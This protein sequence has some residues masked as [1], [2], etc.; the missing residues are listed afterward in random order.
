MATI[1]RSRSKQ[2][3]LQ[4]TSRTACQDG[5]KEEASSSCAA[6]RYRAHASPKTW[7]RSSLDRK[8]S[9]LAHP[10]PPGV[11]ASRPPPLARIPA[12]YA[13]QVASLPLPVAPCPA[14]TPAERSRARARPDMAAIPTR[15]QPGS[16]GR[17]RPS[18]MRTCSC[19][20][21]ATSVQKVLLHEVTLENI[22]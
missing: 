22:F 21:L 6:R 19:R 10:G 4:K 1:E 14:G 5:T 15:P 8:E 12:S 20:R 17:A 18:G 9:R 2:D 11:R 7:P 13:A 16:A 3:F